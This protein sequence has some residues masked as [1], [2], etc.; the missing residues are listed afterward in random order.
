MNRDDAEEYTQALGQIAGGA[1]RQIAL[2]KR[3]GVPKALGLSVEQWVSKRLGGYIRMNVEDRRTAAA[4]LAAD[5]HSTREIGDV[6]GVDHATAARD[7]AV[8]NATSASADSP[9]CSTPA[10]ANATPDA[11]PDNPVDTLGAIAVTERMRKAAHNHR[12][13]GNGEN[14]WYTPAEYIEVARAFMGGIDLDPASSEA[15]QATV[16][17]SRFFTVADDGLVQPWAGRVWL[18]PP[19]AQPA[20]AYFIAKLVEELPNID[21]ALMLTHNYTDTAWF[22]LALAAAAAVCFTRGRIGFVNP[23]GERAT[24]TQGQAIFYFGPDA[25]VHAFAEHF[26]QFGLVVTPL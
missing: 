12:A 17:A 10:V 14:E 15:A 19:Y 18:N 24:P 7:I 25:R 23:E 8:A 2:A 21:E 1:W 3:L 6:L 16:K 11:E 26:G 4:E 9:E 20:I 5:G 22:H 13:Q